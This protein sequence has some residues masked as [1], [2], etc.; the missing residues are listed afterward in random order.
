MGRAELM[1]KQ[2]VAMLLL[3]CSLLNQS[4]AAS[5]LSQRLATSDHILMIRHAYAPGVGD[6]PGYS[7]ERCETQRVLNQAGREQAVRIGQWLRAQGVKEASVLTSIWCRCRETAELLQLGKPTVLPAL[8][9][10]F[11]QPAKAP[12]QNA[13]LQ[14]FVAQQRKTKGS[15][16][17][18]LVTHHVNIQAFMG[19]AIGSGDLV[20]VRVDD[21]GRALSHQT[22]ASP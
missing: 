12:E 2:I 6:P 4:F 5:E 22:F 17:L 9:S 16:A 3:A 15:K 8:A 13:A 20:L 11:D 1:M 21:Q 7:L 10:F 19:K 18:I 14:V